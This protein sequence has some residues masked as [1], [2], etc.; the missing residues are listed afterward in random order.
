MTL[1]ASHRLQSY[2]LHIR[3]LRSRRI[4]IGRLGTFEFPKG[5]YVY[6]G[7]ARRNLQA[8]IRRHLARSK[9][10]KWHIDYLLADPHARVVNV[11]LSGKGECVLNRETSGRIVVAGFG[12]S[13]CKGGCGGHLKF[14]G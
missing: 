11:H 8:R 10:L 6:T 14:L 2:Q 4:T 7:S 9:R 3:L 12:A 5:R 13:D 1:P